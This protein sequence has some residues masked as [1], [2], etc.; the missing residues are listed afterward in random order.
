MPEPT[1]GHKP[2]VKI[3][4]RP[5]SKGPTPIVIVI[6]MIMLVLAGLLTY[7]FLHH[8]QPAAKAQTSIAIPYRT[9]PMAV[10]FGA[11]L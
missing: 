9:A 3:Y 2:P 6:A 5:A 4:D 11:I 10:A 8:A 1:P 7:R